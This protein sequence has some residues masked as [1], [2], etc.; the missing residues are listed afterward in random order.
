MDLTFSAEERAFERQVR[1]F[2]AVNLTAEMKRATALTPS[3]FSDPDIGMAW[4]RAAQARL[5]GAG[6]AG[7]IWRTA[8]DPGAALDLRGR[9]CARRSA[10]RQRDRREDG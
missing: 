4:Q 3:V 9:K 2:I 5:G 6:L 8:L 10:Q 1:D 7:G